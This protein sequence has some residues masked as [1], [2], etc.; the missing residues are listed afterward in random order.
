MLKL[1]HYKSVI[2]DCDGVI[3][4]SNQL[5]TSVFAEVLVSEKKNLVDS[6]I[7]Y[8]KKNGGVSRYKKF[9]YFYKN[10]KQDKDHE[11]KS[12][13]AVKRYSSL[14]FNH[15]LSIDYVPGFINILSY[16]N[17]NNIPCYVVSG[18]DE[19]ELHKIFKSKEIFN[20]FNK[21]LGSPQTKYKNAENLSL[22]NLIKKPAIL[23]GDSSIDMKIAIR[24][25]IDFCF[26]K[27][28]SEWKFGST[29][30]SKFFF[31]NIFNF[32]DPLV[33]FN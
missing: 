22:S 8:H 29:I 11:N 13:I 27:Q 3:L 32:N 25:G 1:C 20:K 26:V 19:I 31:Y 15:L 33:S 28:F 6:F 18:G 17:R 10:I 16:F 7:S 21:V 30:S 24:Y 12:R 14:V 4:Q 9:E 5:K 2:F 23:F